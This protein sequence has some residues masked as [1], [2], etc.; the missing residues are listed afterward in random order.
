MSVALP[1]EK[2]R[3]Y[4]LEASISLVGFQTDA[5]DVE[6]SNRRPYNSISARDQGQPPASA[7]CV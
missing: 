2:E 4:K 6:L 3:G 7:S 1:A 5:A